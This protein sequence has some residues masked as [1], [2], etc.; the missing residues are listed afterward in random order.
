M[1]G[2]H[3]LWRAPSVPVTVHIWFSLNSGP[4]HQAKID[5]VALL[6]AKLS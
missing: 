1:E 3:G 6:L 4:R 5:G 2:D